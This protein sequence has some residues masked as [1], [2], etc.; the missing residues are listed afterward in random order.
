MKTLGVIPARIGSTRLPRKPILDICGKSLIQRVYQS[1]LTS[2]LLSDLIVATDSDEIYSHVK[3]FGGNAILTSDSHQSGTSRV[4]EV[5]EKFPDFDCYLNIQGDS[6]G[7]K[8]EHIDS[9]IIKLDILPKDVP[10]VTT[11]I[12][13][14]KNYDDVKN[15]NHVK[16]VLD[17]NNKGLYF[18]RSEI[19]FLRE[20][21]IDSFILNYGWKHIG[22]Y[23]FNQLAVR[24]IKELKMSFLEKCEMLEQLTWLHDGIEISCIEVG[25]DI[26]SV[27]TAED[28]QHV[29]KLIDVS[30]L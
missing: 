13:R 11:P 2:M 16:V 26:F 5:A 6:I 10:A 4:L 19:P 28:I 12:V 3:S 29:R 1:S 27:D 21:S 18:S 24:R 8:S 17:K 22:L 25:G 23:G 30:I 7:I 9:L 14:F 20:E 15:K